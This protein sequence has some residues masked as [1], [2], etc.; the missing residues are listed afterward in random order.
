MN[1][2]KIDGMNTYESLEASG[3]L[4]ALGVLEVGVAVGGTV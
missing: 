1:Y 2:N 4:S 3:T